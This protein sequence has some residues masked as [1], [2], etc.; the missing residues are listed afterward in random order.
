LSVA[1]KKNPLDLLHIAVKL[2]VLNATCDAEFVSLLMGAHRL[3][4]AVESSSPSPT[5]SAASYRSPFDVSILCTELIVSFR[6]LQLSD[7][8]ALVEQVIFRFIFSARSL[9][10]A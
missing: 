3:L 4:A 6:T 2:S 7:D 1:A 5:A 9:L 10:H 8:R